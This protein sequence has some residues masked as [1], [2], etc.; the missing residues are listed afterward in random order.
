MISHQ[1]F[2]RVFR[3]HLKS[4]GMVPEA[5][6]SQVL[7]CQGGEIIPRCLRWSLHEFG[8]QRIRTSGFSVSINYQWVQGRLMIC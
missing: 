1:L 6:H 2:P 4:L 3:I 5:L 8:F 7:R